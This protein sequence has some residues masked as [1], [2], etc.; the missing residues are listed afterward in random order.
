MICAGRRR[1]RL[2][3]GAVVRTRC[4]PR[5]PAPL[6]GLTITG[7]TQSYGDALLRRAARCAARGPCGAHGLHEQPLVERGAQR[8]GRGCRELGAEL[9]AAVG[10]AGG[11]ST[12][13]VETTTSMRVGGDER[14]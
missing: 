3:R 6:R 14:R 8:L 1:P 4:T 12:S 5:E 7:K 9:V 2:E 10:E 13:T 11:S